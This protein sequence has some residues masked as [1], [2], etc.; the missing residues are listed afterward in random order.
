MVATS[1]PKVDSPNPWNDCVQ[2]ITSSLAFWGVAPASGNAS[3]LVAGSGVRG[4]VVVVAALGAVVE[5]VV[6]VE[7]LVAVDDVVVVACA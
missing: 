3:P 5:V 2:S 4:A 1:G 7:G 6:E